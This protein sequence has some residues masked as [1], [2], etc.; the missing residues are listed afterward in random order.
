M[1][2]FYTLDGRSEQYPPYS[3]KC[4]FC[5]HF[6]D[7]DCA[8][9]PNGIPDK[10]LSGEQIHTQIDDKQEGDFVFTKSS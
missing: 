4:W 8:A 6:G 1:E 10:F 9:F 2:D 5:Q 3:S 7:Y